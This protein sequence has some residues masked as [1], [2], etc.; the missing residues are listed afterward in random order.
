VRGGPALG[1][2]EV[3]SIARGMVVLDAMVKRSPVSVVDSWTVSPG[4]Y[5]VLVTGEVAEVEEAMDAGVDAAAEHLLDE[6]FL[7][8]PDEGVLPAVCGV[9]G[10]PG[11]DSVAVVETTM[12][13][14][15]V[16]A[17]DAAVKA[18]EVRV[19]E[20]RLAAGLGGKAYFVLAGPLFF[21]EAAVEA[22]AD[23]AH[24]DR[25]V[26]VEV[27]ANPHPEAAGHLT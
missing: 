27:I 10:A 13:A 9:T 16:R 25:L 7:P 17:A 2:L 4:K 14:A 18:A 26:N 8:Y 3:E 19:V 24:R 1:L 21:V 11:D 5:L 23:A 22:A 15:A 12:A 20:L 6:V